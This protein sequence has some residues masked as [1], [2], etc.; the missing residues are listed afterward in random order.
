MHPVNTSTT[1]CAVMTEHPVTTSMIHY[2]CDTCGMS[3]TCV[4]NGAAEVAWFDHMATHA[5]RDNFRAWT[6]SVLQL[7]L[8]SD[9]IRG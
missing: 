7:D 2:A 5:V 3:A 4:A 9:P 6:W 8:A 1:Y